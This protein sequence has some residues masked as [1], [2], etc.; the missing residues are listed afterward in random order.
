MDDRA[1]LRRIEDDDAIRERVRAR[2]DE[3]LFQARSFH[4]RLR[5]RPVTPE[6]AFDLRGRAAGQASW[7]QGKP[8]LL[9]FNLAIARHYTDA[10]ITD[11]VAHEVAHLVTRECHPG[12]RPHGREWRAVMRQFGIISPQRCHAYEVG[13]DAVHRQR[14]WLYECGCRIHQLSTTRHRRTQAGQMVYRCRT[15]GE[16]L[17]P[18]RSEA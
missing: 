18:A 11:T 2:V 15:C 9:R 10:F 6:V 1:G 16:V 4:P 8:P 14:R 5:R 13:T 17:S 12:A 7:R 3:L